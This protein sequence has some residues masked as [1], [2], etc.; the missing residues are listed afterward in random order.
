MHAVAGN[1]H[2]ATFQ[3]SG[4]VRGSRGGSHLSGHAKSKTW[5][6]GQASLSSTASPAPEGRWERGRGSRTL[7]RA[8]RIGANVSN[9]GSR[10]T[11]ANLTEDEDEGF[12]A[13][14][15]Y[16]GPSTFATFPATSNGVTKTW[17]EVLRFYSLLSS[18]HSE[19]VISSGIA[20]QSEGRRANPCNS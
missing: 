15:S 6:N 17:E 4:N 1:G 18:I 13:G 16:A 14:P 12:H 3:K 7:K 10:A 9:R 11:S 20:C 19:L 2:V 5:V 8:G